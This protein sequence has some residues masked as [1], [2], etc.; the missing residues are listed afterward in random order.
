VRCRVWQQA[1]LDADGIHVPVA[2]TDE[3]TLV[4][5]ALL[6][7]H[8][9]PYRAGTLLQGSVGCMSGLGCPSL[10]APLPAKPSAST[11]LPPGLAVPLRQSQRR[12]KMAAREEPDAG[13]QESAGDAFVR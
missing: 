3:E 11:A 6:S 9:S 5:D 8:S 7:P 12:L 13:S 2:A 1:V 4:P 10:S